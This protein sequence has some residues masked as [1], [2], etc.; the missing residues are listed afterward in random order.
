M[1]IPNN[2]N[3]NTVIQQTNNEQTTNI[4]KDKLLINQRHTPIN[5]QHC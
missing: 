4:A 1:T 2:S 3:E 5:N